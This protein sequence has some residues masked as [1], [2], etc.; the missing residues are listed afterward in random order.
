MTIPVLFNGVEYKVHVRTRPF[1]MDFLEAI[2]GK[3]EVVVFTA[4]QEVYASELLNRIDPGECV[5]CECSYCS[6]LSC[7]VYFVLCVYRRAGVQECK[8][9]STC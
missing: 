7:I 4:S 6:V 3:F 1:L 9:D 8:A 5:L 2:H